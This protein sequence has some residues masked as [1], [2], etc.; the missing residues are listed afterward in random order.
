MPEGTKT[1]GVGILNV[2]MDISKMIA[3]AADPDN[4]MRVHSIR[5]DHQF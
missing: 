4:N 3:K 1:N 5:F 2:D